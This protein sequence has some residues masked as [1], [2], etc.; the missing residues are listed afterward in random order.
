MHE[1]FIGLYDQTVATG[2]AIC[3]TIQDILLRLQFSLEDLRAQTYDG[4][5]NMDGCH[6]GCQVLIKNL[7][8]LTLHFRCAPH[9]LYLAVNHALVADP[10]VRDLSLI[11]I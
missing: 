4:A 8:P 7:Q 9:C 5:S 2:E 1:E 6:N 10:I 3:K 11:H